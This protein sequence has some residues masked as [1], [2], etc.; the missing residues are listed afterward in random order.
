M[1]SF[2]SDGPA[3][4]ALQSCA[5]GWQQVETGQLF[6]GAAV[7]PEAGKAEGFAVL[8]PVGNLFDSGLFE[9]GWQRGLAG[10]RGGSGK[11]VSSCISYARYS[12]LDTCH[13]TLSA[14]EMMQERRMRYSTEVCSIQPADSEVLV[15]N[16]VTDSIG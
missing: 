3:L 15:S 2:G 8:E 6:V 13:G 5:D 16:L 14:R 12:V 4:V 9:I 1:S 7:R 10:R 11:Q